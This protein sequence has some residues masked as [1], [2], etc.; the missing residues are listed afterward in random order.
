[1]SPGGQLEQYSKTEGKKRA[2]AK[3][4]MSGSAR[5]CQVPYPAWLSKVFPFCLDWI[6]ALSE[7]KV[8]TGLGL[9]AVSCGVLMEKYKIWGMEW[10]GQEE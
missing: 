10:M 3:L 9:E 5:M 4:Q 2:T 6:N 1:M 7:R 8:N